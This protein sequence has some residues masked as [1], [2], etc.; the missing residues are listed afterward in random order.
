VFI[1]CRT[2]GPA[3]STK[4]MSVL[5]QPPVTGLLLL[6]LVMTVTY[7]AKNNSSRMPGEDDM[8]RERLPSSGDDTGFER[9]HQVS[10]PSSEQS[11]DREYEDRTRNSLVAEVDVTQSPQLEN[12]GR[13]VVVSSV[14]ARGRVAKQPT[15]GR[16]HA[17]MRSTTVAPTGED[18]QTPKHLAARLIGFEGEQLIVVNSARGMPMS[19]PSSGDAAT[20]N[21]LAMIENKLR[22]LQARRIAEERARLRR[23]RHRQRME[24][25]DETQQRNQLASSPPMGRAPNQSRQPQNSTHRSAASHSSGVGGSRDTSHNK[26]RLRPTAAAFEDDSPT[27]RHVRHQVSS[28]TALE[29]VTATASTQDFDYEQFDTRR[30]VEQE[31]SVVR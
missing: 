20:A 18:Q 9:R 30:V 6:Y 19:N 14:P 27:R 8:D 24:S 13:Q 29:L 17:R 3:R 1:L 28:L 21:L 4:K 11:A 2:I 23:I 12:S 10:L 22:K 25:R 7:A 26:R 31:S 5:G 16:R 15:S